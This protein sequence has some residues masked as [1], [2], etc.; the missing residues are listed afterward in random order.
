MRGTKVRSHLCHCPEDQK[1]L[2]EGRGCDIHFIN[3]KDLM[4]HKVCS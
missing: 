3:S 2:S 4:M 1:E